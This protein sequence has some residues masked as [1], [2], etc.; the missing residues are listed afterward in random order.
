MTVVSSGKV[1][2]HEQ[3]SVAPGRLEVVRGLLNSWQIPNATRRP[4]DAWA[5]LVSDQAAWSGS[6]PQLP[7]PGLDAQALRD[8]R[9]DL[10]NTLGR[11]GPKLLNRHLAQVPITP[12]VEV[13]KG[14]SVIRHRPA[15]PSAIGTVLSVVV[16]AYVDGTWTRLKA[17][18]DCQWVFFDHTRNASRA[19]CGMYA[20][21]P[22][23]RACGSIAKVRSYRA[24]Q[25]RTSAADL[26]R[27]SSSR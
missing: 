25:R 19:W 3:R 13:S 20:G 17:C 1:A 26:P 4:T 6:F 9:D 15:E 16:D 10:R 2:V 12:W 27:L 22:D 5:E 21:G 7:W 14:R 23:G 18:R 8:L 24:R 11:S